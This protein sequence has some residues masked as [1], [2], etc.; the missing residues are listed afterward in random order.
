L[1]DQYFGD[2]NDY[3]KYGLLRCFTSAGFRLGVCWM[4]TSRDWTRQGERTKYLD[5]APR[6]RDRD[7]AL[8]DLLRGCVRNGRRRLTEL[9]P[10]GLLE[11]AAFFED[12]LPDDATGRAEYFSRAERSLGEANLVLFDPD[13]GFEVRS[14]PFG[15]KGSSGYLYWRELEAA[16]AKGASLVVFQH[17]NL[18]ETHAALVAR[19]LAETRRRLPAAGVFAI[20]SSFVLFVAVAQ[21]CHRERFRQALEELDRRWHG[22]LVVEGP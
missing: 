5:D 8:F 21:S 14:K 6:W 4:K 15:R 16:A 11:G 17:W 12:L 20:R 19:L 22:D 7:A 13:T 9:P 1:K 18:M 10:S 3:R 2:I